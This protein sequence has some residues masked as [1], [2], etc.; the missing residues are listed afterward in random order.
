MKKYIIYLLILILT[1]SILFSKNTADDIVGTW[2]TANGKGLIEI[3][4]ANDGTYQGKIVGKDR[5][6]DKNGNDITTDISNPDPAL[7]NRLIFGL[8]IITKFKFDGDDT[9]TD[10]RIYN[11]EDGKEYKCKMWMDDI[12]NLNLRGYIGFSL[13]GRTEKWTRVK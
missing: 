6:K 11:P 1:T 3:Y 9:W 13:L 10:G 4:K 8:V 12:N 2:R 7:R 5:R